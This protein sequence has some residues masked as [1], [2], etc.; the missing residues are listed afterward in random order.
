MTQ[1]GTGSST[2]I[3]E[4]VPC[5]RRMRRLLSRHAKRTKALDR[6]EDAYHDV[7]LVESLR[8]GGKMKVASGKRIERA[9]A[10]LVDAVIDLQ[11]TR[12]EASVLAQ[13]EGVTLQT[14][15]A[16]DAEFRAAGSSYAGYLAARTF[17]EVI[18]AANGR[19]LNDQ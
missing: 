5:S 1:A 11:T 4:P 16:A 10:E 9:F 13:Q 12:A 3:V 14:V 2:A 19:H 8:Y 15:E 7:V 17:D 6:A 18:E